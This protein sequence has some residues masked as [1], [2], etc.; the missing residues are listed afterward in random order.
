MGNSE[1]NCPKC[2]FLNAAGKKF[3]S[4][5]GARLI[6]ACSKCGTDLICG[7]KFCYYCGVDLI[8][9]AKETPTDRWN[10][11]KSWLAKK[12]TIIP[13]LRHSRDYTDPPVFGGRVLLHSLHGLAIAFSLLV[14]WSLTIALVWLFVRYEENEEIHTRDEAWKDY[15]GALLGVFLGVFILFMLDRWNLISI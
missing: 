3:C 7:D 12:I 9:V 8:Q 11:S 13:P 10:R 4:W 5:C 15:Y 14:H 1:I 2:K 6:L